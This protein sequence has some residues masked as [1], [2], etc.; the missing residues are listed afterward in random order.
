MPGSSFQLTLCATPPLTNLVRSGADV[1]VVA[2]IG[3]HR[4]LDTVRRYS[5][6]LEA[7]RDAA[8]EARLG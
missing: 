4:R 1:V 8:L 5:L 6:P 7:D 3:G 2:E